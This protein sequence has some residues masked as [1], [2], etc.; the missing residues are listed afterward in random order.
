MLSLFLWLTHEDLDALPLKIHQS[1]W[2]SNSMA[3]VFSSSLEAERSISALPR[4]YPLEVV[5][6]DLSLRASWCHL[7]SHQ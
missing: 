7:D 1:I 2:I 3:L 4:S 5:P 6:L